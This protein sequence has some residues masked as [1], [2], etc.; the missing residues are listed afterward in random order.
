MKWKWWKQEVIPCRECQE[1]LFLQMNILIHAENALLKKEYER[2]INILKFLKKSNGIYLAE[3]LEMSLLAIDYTST[4]YWQDL[5][6]LNSYSLV[7]L[8]GPTE[9]VVITELGKE[10][11]KRMYIENT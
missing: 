4:D 2:A 8:I 10:I 7:A 11:L 1:R 6:L 5:I 3:L 9:E